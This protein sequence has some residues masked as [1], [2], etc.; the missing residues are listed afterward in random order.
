MGVI[1]KKVKN[2]ENSR[3]VLEEN[4]KDDCYSIIFLYKFFL[5]IGNNFCDGKIKSHDLK[6]D[7]YFSDLMNPLD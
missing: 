1:M 2:K 5:S 3:E 7:L 4:A 6:E